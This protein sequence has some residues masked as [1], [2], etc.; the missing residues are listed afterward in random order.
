MKQ[1]V[2]IATSSADVERAWSMREAIRGAGHMCACTWIDEVTE[3]RAA[4]HKDDTTVSIEVL[5]QGAHND[6][7]EVRQATRFVYVRSDNHKS[8][9]AATELGI[10][11]ERH[12]EGA[13]C[14]FDSSGKPPSNIF[15][16][17]VHHHVS[18]MYDLLLWLGEPGSQR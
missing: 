14:V 12:G 6:R 15:S 9:G 4:G 10:F 7:V 17:L 11:T 2:Y 1:N 5:R 3:A 16:L 8:E 13:A 18:S